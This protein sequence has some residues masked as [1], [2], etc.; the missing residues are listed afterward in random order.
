MSLKR[1]SIIAAVSV[2]AL[3]AG[4]IISLF[5]FFKKETVIE[6]LFSERTL[7]SVRL[8]IIA[9]TMATL[10]FLIIAIPSAYGLSIF[11]IALG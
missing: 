9:A 2:F 7:F 6:T 1:L 3:Y 10:L 11:T 4:L 8:S 5:Y